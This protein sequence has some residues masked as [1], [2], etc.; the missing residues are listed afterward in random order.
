M[1]RKGV[2][3]SIDYFSGDLL[4]DM[5]FIFSIKFFYFILLSVERV[6]VNLHHD[7]ALRRRIPVIS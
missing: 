1:Y 6:F 3:S 4:L 7:R 5:T 2:K